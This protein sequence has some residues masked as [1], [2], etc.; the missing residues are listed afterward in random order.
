MAPHRC[1]SCEYAYSVTYRSRANSSG[2][3]LRGLC[4][5]AAVEREQRERLELQASLNLSVV[6]EVLLS[7]VHVAWPSAQRWQELVSCGPPTAIL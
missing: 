1:V 3:M 7:P 6:V 2:A 5:V 4:V